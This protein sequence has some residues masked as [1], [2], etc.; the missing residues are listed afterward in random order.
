M[1]FHIIL[2]EDGWNGDSQ[3]DILSNKNMTP[4]FERKFYESYYNYQVNS[5]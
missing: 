1:M 5:N 4:R 3:S 2:K